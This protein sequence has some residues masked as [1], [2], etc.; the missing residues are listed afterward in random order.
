V[1]G[2]LPVNSGKADDCKRKRKRKRKSTK[3]ENIKRTEPAAKTEE[4]PAAAA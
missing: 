4:S 2:T 1:E 3:K